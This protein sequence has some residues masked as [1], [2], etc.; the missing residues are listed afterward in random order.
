MTM[1]HVMSG[2]YHMHSALMKINVKPSLETA[3]AN[4]SPSPSST[5]FKYTAE[6]LWQLD[7]H[8][9]KIM[10]YTCQVAQTSMPR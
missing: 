8:N 10:V 6:A 4:I 9:L 1:Y 5:T 3:D 7:R 2:Q